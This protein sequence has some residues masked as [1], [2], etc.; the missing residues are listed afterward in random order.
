LPNDATLYP[1]RFIAELFSVSERWVNELTRGK[2]LRQTKRGMYDLVP[3]VQAYVRHLNSKVRGIE[4]DGET[5][6]SLMFRKSKA[7]V[8]ERESKARKARYQAD[9]MESK[10][11]KLEDVERQWTGRYVEMKAAMLEFPKRAAFR[12]TDP[13]VRLMIEDEANKFV[14]ELLERYSRDGVLPSGSAVGKGDTAPGID[15]SKV[16][17]GQRMGG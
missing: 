10:L 13:N 11:L 12:F 3:T 14:I 9:V 4:S 5:G 16:D 15:A 17:D 6:E 8:E 1:T 7:E 2:I